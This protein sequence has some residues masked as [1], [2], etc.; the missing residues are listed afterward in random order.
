MFLHMLRRYMF[1]DWFLENIISIQFR[2]YSYMGTFLRFDLKTFDL[3][4]FL[5]KL[6]GITLKIYLLVIVIFEM[7][8]K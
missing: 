5:F 4:N 6:K 3:K 1:S 7:F 8:Q 2:K